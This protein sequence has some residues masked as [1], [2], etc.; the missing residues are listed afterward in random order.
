MSVGVG[1]VVGRVSDQG[2]LSLTPLPQLSFL[3]KNICL[4]TKSGGAKV[5]RFGHQYSMDGDVGSVFGQMFCYFGVKLQSP[6]IPL[7][8]DI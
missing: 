1:V 4:L 7:V 5:R 6:L 3:P 2:L 8:L